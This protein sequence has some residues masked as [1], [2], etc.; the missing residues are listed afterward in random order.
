MLIDLWYGESPMSLARFLTV[1]LTIVGSCAF[2]ETGIRPSSSLTRPSI[3]F[4]LPFYATQSDPCPKYPEGLCLADSIGHCH[5]EVSLVSKT[6]VCAARTSFRFLY[7][8]PGGSE[9]VATLLDRVKDCSGDPVVAVLG[10]ESKEV[11]VIPQLT[12]SPPVPRHIESDARDLLEAEFPV[13]TMGPIPKGVPVVVRVRHV[14]L[15]KF[16]LDKNGWSDDATPY[17]TALSANGK[18]INLG[19]C[20]GDYLFFTIRGKLYLTYWDWCC[21]CGGRSLIVY[22]LSGEVPRKVYENGNL[23]D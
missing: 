23:S 16:S 9:F 4:G 6:E 7:E 5:M 19:K 22:D 14:T 17:A 2:A 12:E 1:M 21:A 8:Q 18:L 3:S 13:K 11:Q 20:T 10:I 15:L